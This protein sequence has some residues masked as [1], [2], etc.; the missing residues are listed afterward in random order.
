MNPFLHTSKQ[1]FFT[2]IASDD[3]LFQFIFEKLP[4]LDR[5]KKVFT[6]LKGSDENVSNF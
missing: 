4:I 2:I 1:T 3:A 5:T 6:F